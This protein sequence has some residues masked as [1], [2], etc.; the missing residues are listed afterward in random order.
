MH[1]GFRKKWTIQLNTNAIL[2]NEK[3]AEA[4]ASNTQSFIAVALDSGCRDTY[5]KIK[6]VDTYDKVIENLR[7][8]KNKGCNIILKY[9]LLPT[10]NDNIDEINSFINVCK[11]LAI[12]HV[13]LS[14]NL[15]GYTDGVKH[16][17]DPDMPESLFCFFTYFVARLQEEGI[18]WDFQIE[19]VSK[20]DIERLEKL[21]R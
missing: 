5:K 14:Q 4:V 9:I 8:Y 12:K 18:Y 16:C 7:K 19:F 11:D 2:Y 1:S 3:L 21:R 20:H 15:S 6:R 17:K 10:Y 13:T